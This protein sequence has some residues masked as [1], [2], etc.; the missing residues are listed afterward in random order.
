MIHRFSFPTDIRVGAG[1][2]SLLPDACAFFQAKR[3]LLVTDKGLTEQAVFKNFLGELQQASFAFTVFAGVCG[4]PSLAQ[5]LAGTEAFRAGQHDLII[6]VGGGAAI[7]VAKVIG[8]AASQPHP[9]FDYVDEPGSRPIEGQLPPVIALPTTAGTGSEVGRSSV[10]SADDTHEKKII[11]S[12]LMMPKM[13]LADPELTTSLPPSLTAATGF[14]ALTHNLEA[15]LTPAWHPLCAGIALEGLALIKEH[16]SEAC[17]NPSSLKARENMLMASLM[18]A[19]AF[20]K[21]LGLTHSFAH[22]LSTLRDMHHGLAN[23][24]M[25]DHAM[26]HYLSACPEKW[27][28]IESRLGLQTGPGDRPGKRFIQFLRDLKNDLGIPSDLKYLKLS[29]AEKSQLAEWTLRDGCHTHG[30]RPVTKSDIHNLI[31]GVA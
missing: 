29:E 15:Y 10:I 25:I 1:C 14:D 17:T 21:G 6:A 13:V 19:V 2:R 9:L 26:T 3:P 20:Q 7:D 23:A 4:N 31:I 18:G 11:F 16:L 12:P 24:V 8:V 22:A 5:V 30:P 27:S 28:I